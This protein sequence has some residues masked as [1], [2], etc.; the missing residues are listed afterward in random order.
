MSLRENRINYRMT[1]ENDALK[2]V[3]V[4]PENEAR[5]REIVREIVEG[6]PPG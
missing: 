1:M 5:A 2:R 3:F 6:T 4:M